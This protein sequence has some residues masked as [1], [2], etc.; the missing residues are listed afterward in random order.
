MRSTARLAARSGL[1]RAGGCLWLI[2]TFAGCDGDSN[3]RVPPVADALV[4]A[5]VD[6][7][8]PDFGAGADPPLTDEMA[9][10]VADFD[11]EVSVYV[12]NLVTGDAVAEAARVRRAAGGLSALLVAVAYAD[13]AGHA[14][15]ICAQG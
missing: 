12:R 3:R 1:L 13:R 7:G 8:R 5:A 4:D 10:A 14:A 9:A 11:G 6:A 15:G 2:L